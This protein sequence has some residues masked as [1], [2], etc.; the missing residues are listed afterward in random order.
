MSRPQAVALLS[1]LAAGMWML[2]PA[3]PEAQHRYPTDYRVGI[4]P[5]VVIDGAIDATSVQRFKYASKHQCMT[6]ESSECWDTE[7]QV[8]IQ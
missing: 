8:V 1:L 3:C 2:S 7:P 6:P 4:Q 5:S